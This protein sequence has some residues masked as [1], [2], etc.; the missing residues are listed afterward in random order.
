[1]IRFYKVKGFELL[2]FIGYYSNPKIIAIGW[3]F[4][5]INIDLIK[6]K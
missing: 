3:L 5:Y 6:S 4:W 2:P 1:M